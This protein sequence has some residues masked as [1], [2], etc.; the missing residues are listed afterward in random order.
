MTSVRASRIKDNAVLGGAEAVLVEYQ[1]A[2][3][4][5]AQKQVE[6]AGGE[7]SHVV[8]EMADPHAVL[9]DL[10][11]KTPSEGGPKPIRPQWISKC[12]STKSRVPEEEYLDFSVIEPPPV[13]ASSSSK[14]AASDDDSARTSKKAKPDGTF[15]TSYYS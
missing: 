7:F 1:P 11:L 14:R 15:L 6:H 5:A 2:K 10:G 13:P 8:T 4:S 3:A 9:R 12:F